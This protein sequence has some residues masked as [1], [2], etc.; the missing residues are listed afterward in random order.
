MLAQ[1]CAICKCTLLMDSAN[2]V[3][4][5]THK[6]NGIHSP[7]FALWLTSRNIGAID[8]QKS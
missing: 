1:V 7:G 3:L 6:A 8:G 2:L 5:L 4:D